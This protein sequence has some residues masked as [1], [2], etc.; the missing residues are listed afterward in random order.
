MKRARH[1]EGED[2]AIV[3]HVRGIEV[4]FL[5][6]QA[7]PRSI[8][9]EAAVASACRTAPRALAW[10]R[11][12]HSADVVVADPDKIVEADGLWTTARNLGLVVY[13]AD[14]VPVLLGGP[15]AIA[16]VH[17]GW[18]GL[19]GRLVA[20]AVSSQPD[21]AAD[22][23]AWVGPAM[24]ACCYEVG[25]DVAARVAAASS[26]DV[27]TAGSGRPHLDLAGA[28]VAQLAEAGVEDVRL[29]SSCTGCHPERW[30]SHRRGA[31]NG[32]KMPGGRMPQVGGRMP[33]VGGRNLAVIWR[34]G[35]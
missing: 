12:V 11:Q 32:G 25:E 26:A 15:R 10:N 2:G 30:W 21:A 7:A 18:R 34:R 9:P 17:A 20:A 3:D 1:R 31:G 13:T 29:V 6:R 33:Q 27:V 23:V 22:L 16:A 14:C 28:A 19:A 35:S 5:G 24:G 4:V 8:A